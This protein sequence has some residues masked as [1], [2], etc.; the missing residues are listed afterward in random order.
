[1]SATFFSPARN[2]I[3]PLPCWLNTLIPLPL[4]GLRPSE[5]GPGWV[6]WI[7]VGSSHKSLSIKGTLLQ[8]F[9]HEWWI[10]PEEALRSWFGLEP[11]GPAGPQSSTVSAA[12]LGF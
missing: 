8:S 3:G 1:M 4:V 2:R 10:C 5:R 6:V 9:L 12:E 7:M 11:P